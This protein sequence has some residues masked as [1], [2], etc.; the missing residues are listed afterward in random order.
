METCIFKD[1]LIHEPY[2]GKQN[3]PGGGSFQKCGW[4]GGQNFRNIW[5]F[6]LNK[7]PQIFFDPPQNLIFSSWGGL[8]NFASW[9]GLDPPQPSPP[10]M[11][12]YEIMTKLLWPYWRQGVLMTVGGGAP[13]TL[14]TEHFWPVR[15]LYFWKYVTLYVYWVTSTAIRIIRVCLLTLVCGLKYVHSPSDPWSESI[16]PTQRNFACPAMILPKTARWVHYFQRHLQINWNLSQGLPRFYVR[17]YIINTMFPVTR[18]TW[19]IFC[20]PQFFWSF[21]GSFS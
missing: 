10:H 3:F 19:N 8:K 20:R 5:G 17:H 2:V 13:C 14:I 21:F 11:P 12:T 15:L 18:P 6:L 4:G 16:W 7:R 1:Y 9:G